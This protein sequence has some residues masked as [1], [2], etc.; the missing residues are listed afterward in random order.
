[1]AVCQVDDQLEL[2]D[3]IDR[4]V[5]G[6]RALEDAAGVDADL[7]LRVRKHRSHS[8]SARR[9]RQIR[10]RHRSREPH[11][12]PRASA[13]WTR[14]LLKNPSG[15]TKSASARSR[16]RVAKAASISRLVLALRTWI[17]SPR[18]RA[19]ACT[20]RNVARRRSIGRIDQHGNRERPWAPARARAPAAWPPTSLVKK[21]MPVR[22]PP[23]RARLATRPSLT[24]SSPT[25]KTIGI[26]VVAALAASARGDAGRGDHGHLTADQIGRQR[27]QAIELPAA[28][29]YSIT[30][31][32]PST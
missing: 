23:G 6:L 27:R 16:T 29:R 7:T 22:L 1:M 8:S 12:A 14:R 10:E 32:W 28:Q 17:C 19:A 2:V 25:P 15:A 13:N 20:S 4:Q 21:L 11:G 24:G 26:V 31:F 5:G 9:L 18:A 3:C 30:T